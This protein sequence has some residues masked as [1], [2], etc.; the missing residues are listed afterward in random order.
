M[1]FVLF[2]HAPAHTDHSLA[3]IRTQGHAGPWT[4]VVC[5]QTSL[6]RSLYTLQILDSFLCPH[7]M[8]A[9]SIDA[10]VR[11]RKAFVQNG[12]LQAVV[13]VMVT[14]MAQM[15]EHTAKG[16]KHMSALLR[17]TGFPI[18][19]RV[20]RQCV[21]L[22][23]TSAPQWVAAA[24]QQHGD[25]W[26]VIAMVIKAMILLDHKDRGATPVQTSID[27]IVDGF[28]VIRTLLR[29]SAGSAALDASSLSKF[30]APK[31]Q[32]DLCALGI[33]S[34]AIQEGSKMASD[35]GI[36]INKLLLNYPDVMVRQVAAEMLAD[37]ASM[38]PEWGRRV[39]EIMSECLTPAQRQCTTCKHFFN[40]LSKLL[41][42]NT[43][44]V[45]DHASQVQ[46]TTM[47]AVGLLLS[48]DK[49]PLANEIM[50]ELIVLVHTVLQRGVLPQGELVRISDQ[51]VTT[52]YKEFLMRVPSHSNTTARRLMNRH[53]LGVNNN[54][55]V[56][57][58]CEAPETRQAA[59]SLLLTC[60]TRYSTG[61]IKI[62]LEAVADFTD[63]TRL[64]VKMS[65]SRLNSAP[66]EDWEHKATVERRKLACVGLKNQGATC[67]MN[68]M[69]QE[70]FL[71]DT[72]RKCILTAPLAP[73]PPE[74][75]EEMWK[76]SICTLENDWNSRICAVCE[77]GERPEKVDP[78]AH[79][80]LLRQLQRTF[81]FMVDSELQ[82]FDP[83]QLV[84]A[85]R[86]LGLHFRV[87]SQNDSMEFFD[88]L[89]E[90]LEREV[91][92]KTHSEILKS[93]FRVRVSS[94]LVSVECPHRKPINAGVFEKSFK[95]NVERM[96]TLER[97]IQETLA[98]E[99][100]T[101]DSRV[102]C[103]I[104][105]AAAQAR[106]QEGVV[107]K[108]MKKTLFFDRASMPKTLC[109]QLNRFQFQGNGTCVKLND[110]LAFPMVLDLAPFCKPPKVEHEGDG[111][112]DD[113]D[114]DFGVDIEEIPD[115]GESLIYDLK[116]I[117]V[118]SG[119]F[120][121]GHYYS[122]AEDPISGKWLKLDDD[123]VSEFDLADLESECFGGIQT[124]VNKWTN[125]VYKTEK[126]ASA[127][128]LFYRRRDGP[129]NPEACTSPPPRRSPSKGVAEAM[130]ATA[131]QG[132]EA[133]TEAVLQELDRLSLSEGN[134]P[135][136][137]AENAAGVDEIL[138]T[139]E[140]MIR[141]SLLFDD[142]FSSFVLDLV[143]ALERMSEDPANLSSDVFRMAMSVMYKSVM[144]AESH[145]RM[146]PSGGGGSSKA[147][148]W[149]T[150]LLRLLRNPQSSAW[151]LDTSTKGGGDPDNL[152]CWLEGG[153]VTC[154][155][156]E[157]R[158]T[159]ARLIM[160]A[161]TCVAQAQ[162]KAN[163]AI[164]TL[165]GHVIETLNNLLVTVSHN[166]RHMT[167]YG[168]V[169][170]AIAKQGEQYVHLLRE[171]DT[172]ATLLHLYL[173]PKS[174]CT[175]ELP[176]LAAMGATNSWPGSGRSDPDFDA[177][178][179]T[180]SMLLRGE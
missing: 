43:D 132:F 34:A 168:E 97:A 95:V 121:F 166:W 103:E 139:N 140:Q 80:E 178:L 105:T 5:N 33:E 69:M 53:S 102:D 126:T 162:S 60:I 13:T 94:Q 125:C 1:L 141:R 4:E 165:M 81:R 39:V 92:G 112:G 160:A 87:T 75:S 52:L 157:V 180:C 138:D 155:V 154:P 93:C 176:K 98:G 142:G 49:I 54:L 106:G 114:M 45:K 31:N 148:D 27:A 70:L 37:M 82:S 163:A 127:Y 109:V 156:E 9:A 161:I 171:H 91:G 78:V 6:W 3:Y 173:G 58:L 137:A 67:Y 147:A 25:A 104:C 108:A 18:I 175:K 46:K 86:D 24:L 35:A 83:I 167:Q 84:D 65:W 113:A 72:L 56:A 7:D 124:T 116:G 177:V 77:Q 61:Q 143:T 150:T 130:S 51:L 2:M 11:F 59:W 128:M 99:L 30:F 73:P 135:T 16:N 79:G 41:L 90:R 159:F 170:E 119:Q 100:M 88:K 85:C 22:D 74:K 23:E 68:A 101:G 57:P 38:S 111:E 158:H 164:N 179:R 131:D 36:L 15:A 174:P 12:G 151:L 29:S 71:D 63:R 40:L 10:A 26:S 136:A 153:L 110:R 123:Q 42:L 115:S 66:K 172:L 117:V 17:D 19:V 32:S 64:P 134:T 44:S 89:L 21:V 50:Y 55:H 107:K 145:P 122:F 62:M 48:A 20:L 152:P 146:Q 144:H 169:I 76:C 120:S 28:V 129:N 14:A 133:N 8:D 47:L 149:Q 118:H 96:G